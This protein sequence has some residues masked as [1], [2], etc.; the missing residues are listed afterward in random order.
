M[1]ARTDPDRWLEEY[2]REHAYSAEFEPDWSTIFGR[3]FDT[4]PDFRVE[5]GGAAAVVEMRGFESWRFAEFMEARRGGRGGSIPPKVTIRPIFVALTDKAAQLEPFAATGEPLVIAMANTGTSDVILDDHHVRSAMFGDL[6]VSIPVPTGGEAVGE[7]PPARLVAQPG[8]GAFRATTEANSP[9]NPRPH[10]SGVAIVHRHDLNAEFVSR[11]L[12]RL[13]DERAPET[14]EA[15]ERVAEEWLRS[16]LA[17]GEADGP[18]GYA[19]SVTYYD[20]DRYALGHGPPVPGNWF[21][22]PRDRRFAFDLTGTVFS[23]VQGETQLE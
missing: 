16:P 9:F 10:V 1:E 3:Q 5:R 11:D 20:L 21:D 19:Y 12:R 6:A 2:A 23:L 18:T 13:L 22:G 14:Q 15:R 8:Y 7:A 4:N 17:R